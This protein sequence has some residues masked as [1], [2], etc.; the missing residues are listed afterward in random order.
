SFWAAADDET[1]L[2]I[3]YGSVMDMAAKLEQ[4][5]KA[6]A[7]SVIACKYRFYTINRDRRQVADGRQS[8]VTSEVQ[9]QFELSSAVDWSQISQATGLGM[10][11]CLELSLYDISKA[12]WHYDPDSFLQNMVDRMTG[13]IE[14]HYPVPVPVNYRAVSNFMWVTM[15]D[16]IRIHDMLQGKFNWTEAEY[17]QAAALRA[18][19]LTYKE[20][21]RHLSPTL[22]GGSAG[23][24]L[25]RYLSPKVVREPT[26]A[27]EL[28]ETSRLVDEYAGKYPVPEIARKIY[29]QLNLG[30]RRGWHSTVSRLLA[31]HPHYQ[32]KLSGIDYI[33]L[34]NCIATGRTTTKLAA[35]ELDVPR[36][37]LKIHVRDLNSRLFSSAWTEEETRKLLDY[38]Q[39]CNLKPDV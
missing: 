18:Q 6:L 28:E 37:A 27:G 9:R 29:M 17:E 5:S 34:A 8:L 2:R 1:L 16:C 32:A 38:V 31:A 14:E 3:I 35:K 30:N 10:R 11:E 7:R 39:T 22:R 13:F 19:G 33:D 24:A 21:A 12:S 26:S 20:V 23:S 36:L 4:A 15:D 25:R